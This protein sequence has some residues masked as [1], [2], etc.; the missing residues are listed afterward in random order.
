[1][2]AKIMRNL[3]LRDYLWRYALNNGTIMAE[4]LN[5]RGEIMSDIISEAEAL[6]KDAE[7]AGH[8]EVA[9]VVAVAETDKKAVENSAHTHLHDLLAWL[10][11]KFASIGLSIK[12][13]VDK[14]F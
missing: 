8:A 6:K 13:E 5:M 9:A 14:I 10:K 7:N 3:R 2:M 1:M 12:T 4:I 11:D